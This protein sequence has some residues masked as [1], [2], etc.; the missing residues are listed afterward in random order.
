M[1]FERRFRDER[2][3]GYS[4]IIDAWKRADTSLVLRSRLF[5]NCLLSSSYLDE[6]DALFMAGW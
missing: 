1:G 5:K 2:F 4:I 3:D 6:L